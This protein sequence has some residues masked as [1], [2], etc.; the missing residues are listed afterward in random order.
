MMT[1]SQPVLTPPE[2]IHT[3]LCTIWTGP[4]LN[5]LVKAAVEF[6]QIWISFALKGWKVREPNID[7]I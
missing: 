6:I 7:F 1:S 2:V 4:S 5:S 3:E